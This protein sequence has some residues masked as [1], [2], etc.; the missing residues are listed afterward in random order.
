[1]S[2]R[3]QR[4]F[5]EGESATDRTPSARPWQATT[6]R[7]GD[8]V[9]TLLEP[10][11]AGEEIVVDIGGT[12]TRVRALESIALGH[13]IALVPIRTRDPVTKYG[14]CIGE[15]TKD[16]PTGGWVH[17]HNLR[18][19]RARTADEPSLA[20]DASAYASAVASALGLSIPPASRGAVAANLVR[21]HGLATD[22]FASDE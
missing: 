5:H 4:P 21:L 18:S 13:K 15:A 17:V 7:A 16:I 3:P 14:E 6:L 10:V 1:M 2:D 11:D 12:A 20:F 22:I 8:N 19:R 9:A